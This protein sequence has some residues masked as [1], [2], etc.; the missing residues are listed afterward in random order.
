MK[1]YLVA[2][3]GSLR[4]GL[5]NH[6]YLRKEGV[7]M[8]GT[9][10]SEAIFTMWPVGGTSFPAITLGGNTPIIFEVYEVSEHVL[11]NINGLEGYYGP[12]SIQNHYE[13]IKIDTPWGEAYTYYYDEAPAG[14]KPTPSGD[15]MEYINLKELDNVI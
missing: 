8:K 3:Y 14:I 12:D 5:G 1:K 13:R 10:L 6:H 11:Q 2:V 9:F 15:W 7:E 4:K